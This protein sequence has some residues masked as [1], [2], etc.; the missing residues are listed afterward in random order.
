LERERRGT[1][2]GR[3]RREGEDAYFKGGKKNKRGEKGDRNGGKWNFSQ[4]QGE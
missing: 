3:G 1:I 4:S 2:I